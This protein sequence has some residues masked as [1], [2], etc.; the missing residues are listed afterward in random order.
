MSYREQWRETGGTPRIGFLDAGPRDA[1]TV[2]LLH[3]LGTDHR[4]WLPQIGPL[5]RTHRVLAPDTRGH[6][7][8]GWAEPT[9]TQTWVSDLIRVLDEAG[10]DRAALVGVSLGGIQALAAAA[11]HPA[12]VRGVVAADSFAQLTEEEAQ[13]KT[14][15]L[16][17][18]ART[19]GMAGLADQYV[20]TTFTVSPLPDAAEQVR[21][22]IAGMNVEAYAATARAC[23]GVALE[24]R[25]PAVRCPVLVMWGERDAKAPR[26]LSARI[27]AAV[28]GATLTVV[29]SA[30]HLSNAENPEF[31]TRQVKDF[32][33]PLNEEVTPC[34]QHA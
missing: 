27:A 32:L 17:D 2:V 23:F 7:R 6:G 5:A 31:F 21:S 1:A 13:A 34:G 29:P 10:C 24:D 14:S 26:E 19:A 8:S 15:A 25:L 18:V 30:G 12:R 28:P 22:A 3:S 4:L 16:V 11:D 20:R 33:G 9:S